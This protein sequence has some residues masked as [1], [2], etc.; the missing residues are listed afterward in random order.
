[1]I[2]RQRMSLADRCLDKMSSDIRRDMESFERM[3]QEAMR[4]AEE[5]HQREVGQA[6]DIRRLAEDSKAARMSASASERK[7]NIAIII[8]IASVLIAIA[9]IAV[10]HYDSNQTTKSIVSAIQEL[11]GVSK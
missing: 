3:R 1:M 4:Q 2:E 6:E 7:S 10:A 5:K 8:A 11:K 9:A